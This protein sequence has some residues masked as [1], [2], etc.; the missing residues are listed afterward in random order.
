MGN[1][2]ITLRH[3]IGD[4]VIYKNNGICEICDIREMSFAGAEKKPYYVLKPVYS[5]GSHTYVPAD[6]PELAQYMHTL[7]DKEEIHRAIDTYSD[8][9]LSWNDDTKTR[10]EYF[11]SLILSFDRRAILAVAIKLS[12][13]KTK[14]DGKRK[15]MYASDAKILSLAEKMIK[16][17]FAFVLEIKRDEVFGYIKSRLSK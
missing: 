7:L 13:Y 2:D 3:K 15:K 5:L 9:E 11:N 17:E 8:F 6:L 4:N 1:V 16:D 10:A 14:L 12:E